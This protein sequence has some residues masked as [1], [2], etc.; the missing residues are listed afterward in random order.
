MF[1]YNVLIGFIGCKGVKN[2][3]DDKIGGDP[4]TSY[5]EALCDW[6]SGCEADARGADAA[7]LNASCLEST[8]AVN[9]DCARAADGLNP[10]D[11]ELL[12]KCTDAIDAK[13]SAG[14]CDGFTGKAEDWVAT[15]PPECATADATQDTFKSARE[16][17]A[18]TN[19]EMCDRM[20]VSI[21]DKIGD[22][23][24]GDA[25][26]II[27]EKLT[28]FGFSTVTEYCVQ[29]PGISTWVGTCK[30]NSLYDYDPQNPS[31]LTAVSCMESFVNAQCSE[32]YSGD[33]FTDQDNAACAGAFDN[34]ADII[35]ALSGLASEFDLP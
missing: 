16:A 22:C 20:S 17:V 7:A 1:I 14:E 11:S 27:D 34:P 31:R 10:A 13:A 9:E 2:Q 32:L 28:E 25:G 8:E 3:L 21:C 18:E 12:T 23:V 33:F 24:L 4:Q 6:A 26:D 35:S 15:T 5:C 19:D 29:L 30:S